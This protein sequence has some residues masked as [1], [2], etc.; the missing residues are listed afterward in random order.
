MRSEISV[1][2]Y[3]VLVTDITGHFNQRLDEGR[4]AITWWIFSIRDLFVISFLTCFRS[5][6]DTRTNPYR[7]TRRDQSSS[8]E[9]KIFLLSSCLCTRNLYNFCHLIPPKTLALVE[10]VEIHLMAG[11]MVKSASHSSRGWR[12]KWISELPRHTHSQS[13]FRYTQPIKSVASRSLA[14]D[15]STNGWET[16]SRVTY[17]NA[18][19]S[20]REDLVPT[21]TRYPEKTFNSWT[22]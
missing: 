20:S 19:G 10:A 22:T 4:I 18:A 6:L 11:I 3:S 16:Y 5:F 8:W 2:Y 7:S 21:P 1:F 12:W 9:Y 13:S 15:T 14:W 17:I